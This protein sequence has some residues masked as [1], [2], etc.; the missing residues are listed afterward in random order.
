M[1]ISSLILICLLQFRPINLYAAAPKIVDETPRKQN[2]AAQFLAP[3]EY[4]IDAYIDSVANRTG[5]YIA[6]GSTFRIFN[7]LI[8]AQ[9]DDVIGIDYEVGTTEFNKF[10]LKALEQSSDRY[11]F[12][13]TLFGKKKGA[14]ILTE[15]RSHR[16]DDQK[17]YN[18]L[19]S[20]AD[21]NPRAPKL[22]SWNGQTALEN[23]QMIQRQFRDF[24]LAEEKLTSD[25][26]IDNII[27]RRDAASEFLL[28]N[29]FLGSDLAYTKLLDKI[30]TTKFTFIN[31]NLAG[32]ESLLSVGANLKYR[33][34]DVSVIDLS[35][36]LDYPMSQ[37][38]L[39]RLVR[40]IRSLPLTPDAIILFTTIHGRQLGKTDDFT[41]MQMSV[42]EFLQRGLPN[43]G[44]IQAAEKNRETPFKSLKVFDTQESNL[45]SCAAIMRG[46]LNP[47]SQ[48]QD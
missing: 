28:N 25:S 10:V 5:A 44:E 13:A 7:T 33:G 18:W 35:N 22:F 9:F 17:Y 41:Y 37:A 1:K 12:L 30:R 16:I 27:L 15:V 46:F 11:E 6:V 26:Q 24:F 23:Y 8:W 34:I 43:T 21:F 29:S 38:A 45:K 32:P 42:S 19:M 4:R 40:N 39:K 14:P 3:N 47:K 31:G 36:A 48:H 20:D 2:Y